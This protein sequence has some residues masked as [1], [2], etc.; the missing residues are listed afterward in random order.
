MTKEFY[1]HLFL[2]IDPIAF[3]I[4]SFYIRWY[5]IMFLIGFAVAYGVLIFRLRRGES[6]IVVDQHVILDF[7]FVTFFSALAGG[8][9]GYVLLYNLQY[10]ISKPFSIISPYDL[11]GNFIGIF[12][13]SYHGALVGIIIGSWI[14]LK[15]KKINFFKWA[16]FVVPAVPIGYFFGR[17]GNFL[18]GEL[19][20]RVTDSFLGI[21]FWTDPMV[22]RFPSQL[23]EA[24][25][26]GLLLFVI[27]WKIRKTKL[28]P[29]SLLAIYLIGYGTFRIFGECFREPDSQVGLLLEY[30][31]M[32]QILSLLMICTGVLMLVLLKKEK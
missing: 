8:R 7:V 24:L 31:T 28:R 19:Y 23:L 32:G 6:D 10:F 13:M 5:A 4:G 16:D 27:L 26:E 21:Y 22:L 9:A 25:L 29:G 20:G 2:H 15:I 14:F 12:G 30:F 1:Q 11:D 17:I 3:T 18:N